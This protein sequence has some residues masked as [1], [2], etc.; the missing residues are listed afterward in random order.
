VFLATDPSRAATVAVRAARVLSLILVEG[1]LRGS[2][3]RLKLLSARMMRKSRISAQV[4]M[5]YVGRLD[6]GMDSLSDEKDQA[7]RSQFRFNRDKIR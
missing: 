5:L 2:C 4:R 3:L 6:N 7:N 1:Q